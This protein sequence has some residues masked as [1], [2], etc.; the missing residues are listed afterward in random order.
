MFEP[1]WDEGCPSCSY[2]VDN[3]G[4]LSHLHARDTSLVLVSR[5]PF[6]KL[7]AYRER[8]GWT[9]PW[10]SSYGS[11]FNYDF[12]VTIDKAVAPV[13]YNYKGEEEVSKRERRGARRAGSSWAGWS[14]DQPGVSAFLREGDRVFHTYSGYERGVEVLMGTYT[15][16]DLTARGRQED[17]EEPQGRSDGPAMGWLHRH[18]QY[19][20]D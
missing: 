11:D 5:A 10:Y 3:I 12:H 16:L 20:D 4:H 8:M 7:A 1:D 19:E 18:D 14:G 6:E 9:V 17:W 13:E 2:V 15:W